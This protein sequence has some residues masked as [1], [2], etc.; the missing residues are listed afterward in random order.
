MERRKPVAQFPAGVSVV[1][2]NLDWPP[3]RHPSPTG[4]G[5]HSPVKKVAYTIGRYLARKVDDGRRILGCGIAW[6]LSGA[7]QGPQL[8]RHAQ[9]TAV[10]R[11]IP[12]HFVTARV[13]L[14][15]AATSG[16]RLKKTMKE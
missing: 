15:G 6:Y 4:E 8:T 7:L 3:S 12:V 10:S 5:T 16:E 14:L 1:I 13:G 11:P 2:H 9:V